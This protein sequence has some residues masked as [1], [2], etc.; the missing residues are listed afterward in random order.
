VADG[1]AIDEAAVQTRQ[2]LPSIGGIVHAAGIVLLEP[3]GDI[4]FA[5]FN[6]C[7]T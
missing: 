4:D 5:N 7:S 2:A 1:A 6:G 3:I